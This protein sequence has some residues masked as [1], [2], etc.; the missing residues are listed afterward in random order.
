MI[1]DLEKELDLIARARK[2]AEESKG[3]V[4]LIDGKL[5]DITPSPTFF[6]MLDKREE[7]TRA[8]L[9]EERKNEQKA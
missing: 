1:S 3:R 9:E 4:L 7:Q 6:E 8:Q 5:T 2:G